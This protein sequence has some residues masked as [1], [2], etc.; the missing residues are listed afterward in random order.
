MLI[1]IITIRL[2]GTPQCRRYQRMRDVALKT[3]EQLGLEIHL[4]EINDTE[5]LSQSN[6]FDLPR[7]YLNGELFATRN[8]P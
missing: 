4:D 1:E 7:L 6:P 5:R 3:A 8:P 2:L